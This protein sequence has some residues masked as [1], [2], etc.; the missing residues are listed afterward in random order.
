MDYC[1]KVLKKNLFI[2]GIFIVVF[3]LCVDWFEIVLFK[4]S[5]FWWVVLI[6]RCNV[7]VK[8]RMVNFIKGMMYLD[9]I[10]IKKWRL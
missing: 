7:F 3:G 1:I 4:L 8:Y 6:L 5:I 10:C 2:D 9:M